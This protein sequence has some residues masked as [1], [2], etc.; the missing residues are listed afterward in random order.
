MDPC[1]PMGREQAA[2]G[3][4]SLWAAGLCAAGISALV[5]A[6]VVIVA[7]IGG[8]FPRLHVLPFAGGPFGLGSVMVVS[9]AAALAGTALYSILWHRAER[10]MH[11][12]ALLVSCVLLIS[13]AGPMFEE[14][15]TVVRLGVMELTHLVVAGFTVFMLWRWTRAGSHY[16][17]ARG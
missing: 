8:V 9:I 11:V 1:A 13:F 14:D 6:I 16:P 5:N 3:P 4:R 10:P 7:V 17:E 2:S 15:W 12:F